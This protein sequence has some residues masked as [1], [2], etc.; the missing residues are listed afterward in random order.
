M[1]I[2]NV[3]NDTIDI[4]DFDGFRKENNLCTACGSGNSKSLDM[5]IILNEKYTNGS[6]IYYVVKH[7]N[8][9]IDIS[10]YLSESLIVYNN[11]NI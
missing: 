9:E 1:N 11:I 10:K 5:R 6:V 7:N 8:K 2:I 3:L 4:S